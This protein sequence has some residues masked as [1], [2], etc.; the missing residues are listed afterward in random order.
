MPPWTYLFMEDDEASIHRVLEHLLNSVDFEELTVRIDVAGLVEQVGDLCSTIL[1]GRIKLAGAQ[2]RRAAI[3]LYEKTIPAIIA[4]RHR[5]NM[6]SLLHRLKP[7]DIA[8]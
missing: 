1:A 7:A 5:A 4:D 3:I 2:H 8:H 6:A